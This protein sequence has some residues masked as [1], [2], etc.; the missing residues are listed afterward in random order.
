MGEMGSDVK[1]NVPVGVTVVSDQGL[2]LADLC[3][4]GEST[5]VAR[6]METDWGRELL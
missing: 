6:G 3:Q 1:I 5:V 4:D 2:V